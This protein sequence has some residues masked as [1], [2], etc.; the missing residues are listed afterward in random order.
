M[1]RLIHDAEAHA[2]EDRQRREEVETR[3]MADS[4]A[5]NAEKLLRDNKEKIPADMNQEVTNKLTALRSA[6]LD[7][8]IGAISSAMT[9]LQESM[10]K[11]GAAVYSQAGEPGAEDGP[12]VSDAPSDASGDE[13]PPEDTVEG[14][15][16][17]V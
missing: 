7:Q 11:V 6:L 10:Q 12:T 16:R 5:Y 4:M 2:D 9:D 17:E 8:D 14:E 13:K 3:N 1:E 15:F